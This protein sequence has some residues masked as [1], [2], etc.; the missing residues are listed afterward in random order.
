MYTFDLQ[1]NF[2]KQDKKK[3]PGLHKISE[4]PSV[5][6]CK[7]CFEDNRIPLKKAVIPTYRFQPS[8]PTN[9]LT[10]QHSKEYVPEF[11]EKVEEKKGPPLDGK[12]L[13]KGKIQTK[14]PEYSTAED[15][16][17]KC[18]EFLY[19][20]FNTANISI[21]Q[22][23]NPNLKALLRLLI[24]NAN[25]LKFRRSQI[26]FS[27]WRYKVQECKVF[28]TFTTFLTKAVQISRDHYKDTTGKRIPFI[29]V[30]HDAWDSKRRDM[31]GC[32]V[33]FVH[34]VYWKVISLP[35]GLKYLTS[36]KATDMVTQLN[37]ILVR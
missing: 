36:K 4:K 15:V 26:C 3:Y 2:C 28:N 13:A 34:P 17:Q 16:A 23:G 35:V 18:N 33:H 29:T 20:F 11:W 7:V 32:C 19:R 5:A 24:D 9:H 30:S 25:L 10:T 8:N 1:T 27:A 6:I 31:L 21:N 37:K 12:K 22:A 14:I